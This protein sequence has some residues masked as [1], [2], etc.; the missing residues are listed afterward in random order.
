MEIQKVTDTAFAK[1]GKVMSDIPVERILKE[2]EHTPLPEDVISAVASAYSIK[3]AMK[4]VRQYA[5]KGMEARAR[6]G[7]TSGELLCQTTL[8]NYEIA[9]KVG[10]SDPHYFSIAFKKA[11][12][13]TPKEYARENGR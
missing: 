3:E 7:Q 1:Y 9:E 5:A 13:M 4:L 8:K 12:G 6:S 10:F 11:T 2:M